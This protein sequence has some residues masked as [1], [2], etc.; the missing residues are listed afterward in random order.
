MRGGWKRSMFT[1]ASTLVAYS[2]PVNVN[3]EWAKPT[4]VR[5][6]ESRLSTQNEVE[7]KMGLSIEAALSSGEVAATGQGKQTQAPVV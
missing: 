2:T 6:F 3:D 7:S 1:H 5:Q 4:D